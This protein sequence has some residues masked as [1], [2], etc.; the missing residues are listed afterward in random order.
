[1]LPER[2][3]P[4]F[5]KRLLRWHIETNDDVLMANRPRWLVG[6][7]TCELLFQ[8]PFFFYA[9][10]ALRRRDNGARGGLLAYG[11]HTA[12]T[13]VPILQYIWEYPS[14]GNA[15]RWRLIAIY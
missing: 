4:T 11:A 1:M 14:L 2:V 12:T 5:A 15:E 9:V 3:G 7:V 13:L 6:L 8:L 10:S